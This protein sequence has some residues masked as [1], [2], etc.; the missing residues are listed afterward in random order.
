YIVG[1]LGALF[2]ALIGISPIYNGKFLPVIYT[3]ITIL[4]LSVTLQ[5]IFTLPIFIKKLIQDKNFETLSALAGFVIY[6]L[7]YFFLMN[8]DLFENRI[9]YWICTII[10]LALGLYS[11]IKLILGLKQNNGAGGLFLPFGPAL[12]VAGLVVIFLLPV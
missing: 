8:T 11:C 7:V 5:I 1:G 6:T 10:L 2:G 3:L 4:I 12:I 9:I